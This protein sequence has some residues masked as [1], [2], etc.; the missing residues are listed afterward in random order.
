MSLTKQPAAQC[1]K[2]LRKVCHEIYGK[3]DKLLPSFYDGRRSFIHS[4]SNRWMGS[5]CRKSWDPT[6][7]IP[8]SLP[9]FPRG[10]A[11]PL[12]CKGRLKSTIQIVTAAVRLVVTLL[13]FL[14]FLVRWSPFTLTHHRPPRIAWSSRFDWTSR[15]VGSGLLA[16]F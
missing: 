12:G 4:I 9:V 2:S 6:P 10:R 15:C 8:D 5:C 13:L 3:G 1:A 11:I 16:G 7:P 14:L